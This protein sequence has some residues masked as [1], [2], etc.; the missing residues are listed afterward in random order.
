MVFVVGEG[1]AVVVGG[2][3]HGWAWLCRQL[4]VRGMRRE[5]EKEKREGGRTLSCVF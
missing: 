5:E 1:D 3:T 4:L 2:G